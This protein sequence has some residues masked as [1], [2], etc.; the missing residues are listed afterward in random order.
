MKYTILRNNGIL[1]VCE[2][3]K[4]PHAPIKSSIGVFAFDT[5]NQVYFDN[6]I[7][8]QKVLA[9]KLQNLKIDEKRR[10]VSSITW[11]WQCY[12]EVNGFYMS[13]DFYTFLSYLCKAGLKLGWCYN[14][15]FDFSQIDYEILAK[16]RDEWTA[17]KHAENGEAYDKGQAYTYES[18]HDDAGARFAYKLWFPYHNKNR[19]NYVHSIEYRDF[20]KFCSGGLKKILEDMKIKDDEGNDLRKLT[21]EY[22]AVDTNNLSEEEIDYCAIDVKGLYFA[23]KS[24]DKSLDEQSNGESRIF[25]KHANIMTAGGFAKR[26]LL[27][28]LYPHK[29]NNEWRLEAYQREHP[30]TPEQDKYFR[31]NHLYRGGLCFVNPRFKGRLLTREKMGVPLYRYDVNSEYPYSMASIRDLVGKPFRMKYAEWLKKPKSYRDE[32][33]AILVC[34]SVSGNVKDGFLGIWYDPFIKDFVDHIEEAGKHLIY[35]R[36]LNEY[37]HWYDLEIDIDDVILYK[38][39]G[40]A[41]RPF[42]EKNYKL[43]AEA[44]ANGN[45]TLKASSKLCLNSSYGK[46]AE[47]TER[48]NGH[49]EMSEATGAIHYVRDEIESNPAKALNVAVG[50]LVTSFARCYILSKIREICPRP[51]DTFVYIDTDSIHAFNEYDGCD[52]LK[53]G[54]L[55]CE[56]VCDAVKYIAP[57]TYV[58][59]EKVNADGTIDFDKM[60]IHAKGVNIRAIYDDLAKKQKGKKKGLPTLS[61]IDSKINYGVKYTCLSAMNVKGGKALLPTQKYLARAT[62]APDFDEQVTISNY[63]GS[64]LCER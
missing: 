53:L 29:K 40:Y 61:L 38:R 3:G 19:H 35:E 4:D 34:N 45:A 50:A 55:K 5:E 25:S 28:S 21:I 20:M 64:Y 13:N 7:Y 60:E 23:V 37:A 16:H 10:R 42:I 14:A 12:D 22:Q 30:L 41:Y 17:H 48:Q 52:P 9:K 63:A 47:R 6:K 36:E 27:K 1:E 26:Q 49:Y 59:V 18:L 46:L 57:K 62:Q 39:G 58:D 32:Y 11:A 44:S 31:E 43:K 2:A 51:A 33:E 15:T 54:A 24:F 56:A 8:A